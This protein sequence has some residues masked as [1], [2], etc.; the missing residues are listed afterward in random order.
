MCTSIIHNG[1][2]TT[3]GW[4]LDVLDMEYCVSSGKQGVYI[5]IDDK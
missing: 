2:K 4:N 1:K 5:E 3:I